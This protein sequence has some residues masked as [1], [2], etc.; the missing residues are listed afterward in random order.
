MTNPIPPDRAR[1]GRSNDP[2]A[3]RIN[4]PIHH[5]THHASPDRELSQLAARMPATQHPNPPIHLFPDTRLS[6]I[7]ASCYDRSCDG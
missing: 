7:V 5:I 1:P 4:V 6:R 2:N 3:R